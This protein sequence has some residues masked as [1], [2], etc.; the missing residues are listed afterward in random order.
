MDA[1]KYCPVCQ[2]P[3]TE[4]VPKRATST[5]GVKCP[6]CKSNARTRFAWI[7]FERHTDLLD[8]SPKS[9]LHFA[10]EPSLRT[11]LAQ[12]P[13]L[14]YLT[15]DIDPAKAMVRVDITDIQFDD[16]HFDGV[17]CS[18][19]LEHVA[20]DRRAIGEILRVLK[21]G[22]WA[23]FV[24][25]IKADQTFED[26]SITDPAERERRFGQHD[27][28]RLY[29]PDFLDRLREAGFLARAMRPADVLEPG[30]EA[31]FGIPS[32]SSRVIFFATKPT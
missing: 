25:P 14:D 32:S 30:E 19:V 23:V 20:K 6:V 27:H 29:G 16:D 8:G 15:A 2:S 21:P 12:V 1:A 3:V 13:G 22:G 24:V 11:R 17:Y 18:H 4:F 26:P 28:V 31:T 7:F 5:P 9:L 10:P